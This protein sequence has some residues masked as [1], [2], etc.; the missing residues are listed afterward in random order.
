MISVKAN[1]RAH[2]ATRVDQGW[3]SGFI[4]KYMYQGST[5][6]GIFNKPDKTPVTYSYSCNATT[7]TWAYQ[8]KVDDVETRVSTQP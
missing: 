1:P 2:R 6:T 5:T 8:G 7:L 4:N 3:A